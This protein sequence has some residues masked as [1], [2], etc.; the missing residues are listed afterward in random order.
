LLQSWSPLFNAINLP[1]WSLSDEA[2][3]YAL[4]PFVGMFL[5]KMRAQK[6]AAFGVAL[7]LA[8][9]AAETLLHRMGRPNDYAYNLPLLGASEFLLG[10]VAGMVHI[11]A[12]REERNRKLLHKV[13]L[14]L[15][16]VRSSLFCLTGYLKAGAAG[17][18]DWDPS[19][20]DFN[21]FHSRAI[22][23]T[24][25]RDPNPISQASGATG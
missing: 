5:W 18:G 19:G 6:A 17:D 14:P 16:I 20:A 4:F 22:Q 9:M 24:C 8:T 12:L 2:F 11:H 3:F 21:R 10:I 1:N 23:R 15:L 25:G 7:F 13:A